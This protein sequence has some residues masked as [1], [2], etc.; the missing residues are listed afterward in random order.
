MTDEKPRY[1]KR[2]TM[3]GDMAK[4]GHMQTYRVYCDGVATPIFETA[5]KKDRNSNWVTTITFDAEGA[6]G[7]FPSIRAA[8]EAWEAAGKPH[9]GEQF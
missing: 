7:E 3:F 5:S 4:G 8:I 6:G 9:L 1:T 2:A